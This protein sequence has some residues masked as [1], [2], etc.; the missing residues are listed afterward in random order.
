MAVP[1]ARTLRRCRW[2]TRLMGRK[3]K[4]WNPVGRPTPILLLPIPSQRDVRRSSRRTV[5]TIRIDRSRFVSVKLILNAPRADVVAG[6]RYS[7]RFDC[8]HHCATGV[9]GKGILLRLGPS[10]QWK[11]ILNDA[12]REFNCLRWIRT[13]VFYN[14]PIRLMCAPLFCLF[15]SYFCIILHK[16]CGGLSAEFSKFHWKER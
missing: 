12:W 7:F 10:L 16:F 15:P 2:R 4:N 3:F 11:S 1:D 5:P 8:S 9:F 6:P 13:G 14:F